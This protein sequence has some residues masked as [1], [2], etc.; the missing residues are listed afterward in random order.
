MAYYIIQEGMGKLYFD[1]HCLSYVEVAD[2]H[3]SSILSTHLWYSV[4]V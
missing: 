4:P 2:N 1:S 3:H